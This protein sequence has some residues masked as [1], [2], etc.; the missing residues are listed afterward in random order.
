MRLFKEGGLQNLLQEE[1][2][3]L[4]DKGYVGSPKIL[5][6]KRGKNISEEEKEVNATLNQRRVVVEHAFS[7]LKKFKCLVS[8]FRNGVEAQDKLFNLCC[9]LCNLKQKEE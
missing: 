2:R 4:G 8:P 5:T 9:Q 1:E 6:P 7:R 3:V